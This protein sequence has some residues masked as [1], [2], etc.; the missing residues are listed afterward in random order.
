MSE[1]LNEM[2]IEAI[3]RIARIESHLE[4]QKELLDKIH[5]KLDPL[6][7]TVQHHGIFI[8]SMSWFIGIIVS[9]FTAKIVGKF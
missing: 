5:E 3:S 2:M 4:S 9:V 8:K 6:M 1:Q 7:V